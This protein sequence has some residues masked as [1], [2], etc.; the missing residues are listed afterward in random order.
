M[1]LTPL[2][3]TVQKRF[4]RLLGTKIL[5]FKLSLVQFSAIIWKWLRFVGSACIGL[6][7]D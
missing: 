1:V 4:F 3:W 7:L 6:H 5:Y 2:D